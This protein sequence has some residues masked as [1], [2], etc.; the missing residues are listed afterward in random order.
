MKVAFLTNDL[1]MRG[2][3]STTW[4]FARA[5]EQV[6]RNQSIIFTF[7]KL[8]GYNSPNTTAQSVAWF[9]DHFDTRFVTPET[10]DGRMVEAG[11]DVCFAE[12]YGT[13]TSTLPTSVPVLAHCVFE[14]RYKVGTLRVA[15]SR[16]VARQCVTEDVKVLHNPVQVE[17]NSDN[18]RDRL[19]IPEE[20]IVFGRYGGYET[21]DFLEV[22]KIVQ[23]VASKFSNIHFVFM[24]TEAFCAG[25]KQIH[26]LP[27]TSDGR[28]KR[29]FIN[30]CD[31]M[32]HARQGGETF[33]CSCG[34]FAICGKSVITTD[35][36]KDLAHIELLGD[37][38]IVYDS[39]DAL[40][41]IL[42]TFKPQPQ[43]VYKTE[44]HD[45]SIEKLI[46]KLDEYL[47]QA[48]TLFSKRN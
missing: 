10:L 8:S 27:G 31:A 23:V 25:T 2:T 48:Q 28:A 11:I 40:Y 9:T 14:S 18:L 20:A 26:F 38:A 17:M 32:L 3:Q 24:N 12:V 30:T 45:C 47:K 13:P 21:F 7:E 46:P 1:Q 4:W 41:Q 35:R 44:Y 22:H 16:C 36:S 43:R 33:G 29:A 39:C 42:T 15:V 5:N 34:E 37:A 19:S 6:L